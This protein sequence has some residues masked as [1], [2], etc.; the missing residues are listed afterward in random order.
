MTE[1]NIVIEE[2]SLPEIVGYVVDCHT[3]SSA[4]VYDSEEYQ[5]SLLALQVERDSIRQ[6]EQDR[7]SAKAALVAATGLTEEQINLLF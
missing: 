2:S 6:A 1:D 3:G 7:E 5:T 4:P